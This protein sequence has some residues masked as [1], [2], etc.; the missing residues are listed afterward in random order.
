MTE[1][2]NLILEMLRD[3]RAELGEVRATLRNHTLRLGELAL[4]LSAVRRDQA[5]DAEVSA[6]LAIRVDR[7]RD[8]VDRI[9]RR[10]ELVD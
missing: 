10:L 4:G 5:N 9:K 6:H 1:P 7:L 2:T 8:D 3:I